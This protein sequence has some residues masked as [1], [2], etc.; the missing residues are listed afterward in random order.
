MEIQNEIETSH[1]EPHLKKGMLETLL[2][3]ERSEVRLTPPLSNVK[4]TASGRQFFTTNGV[5]NDTW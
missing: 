1:Y 5:V 4:D 3:S 2:T